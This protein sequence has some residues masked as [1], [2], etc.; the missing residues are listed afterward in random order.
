MRYLKD[1][2]NTL[3]AVEQAETPPLVC[4][5]GHV[6]I[7][8]GLVKSSIRFKSNGINKMTPTNKAKNRNVLDVIITTSNH[9]IKTT[10]SG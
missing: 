8:S 10:I 9:I 4:S 5:A 7:K 6:S 1:G 2:A 3:E